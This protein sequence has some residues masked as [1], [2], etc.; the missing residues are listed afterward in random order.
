[1]VRSCAHLQVTVTARQMANFK[2]T[3]AADSRIAQTVNKLREGGNRR[4][5]PD[6]MSQKYKNGKVGGKNNLKL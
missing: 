5:K 3:N 4:E 2:L 1:M 6:K